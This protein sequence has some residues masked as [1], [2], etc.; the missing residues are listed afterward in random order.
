MDNR[1]AKRL[2][3]SDWH[4]NKRYLTLVELKCSNNDNL[5][6]KYVDEAGRCYIHWLNDEEK[7]AVRAAA[8]GKLKIS[9]R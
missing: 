6:G 5:C 3:S 7:A 4:R 2:Q 9:R 8:I 1:T